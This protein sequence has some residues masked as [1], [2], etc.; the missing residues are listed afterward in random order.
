M[1]VFIQTHTKPSAAS[2]IE[3]LDIETIPSTIALA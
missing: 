1:Y 2:N 3:V